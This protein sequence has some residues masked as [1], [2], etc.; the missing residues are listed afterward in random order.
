M[1][2]EWRQQN[3]QCSLQTLDNI[4]LDEREL[5]FRKPLRVAARPPCCGYRERETP[6]TGNISEFR[7]R[8]AARRARPGPSTRSLTLTRCSA[9]AAVIST[10]S[11]SVL[12]K[13][14]EQSRSG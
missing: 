5:T 13:G 8:L 10:T 6:D 7:G 12:L 11:P 14:D 3:F 1:S 4:N 9:T 2:I